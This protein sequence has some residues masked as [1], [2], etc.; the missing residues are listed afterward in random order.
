MSETR[1]WLSRVFSGTVEERAVGGPELGVIPPARDN[2]TYLS[3]EQALSI[4]AVY[5]AVSVI[6]S[7][8]SQMPLGVYRG[9]IEIDTPTLIKQPNVDEP[10]RAFVKKTVYSL[11]TTG[12]AYWRLTGNYPNFQN[13]EVLDPASVTVVMENG[14]PRYGV[15]GREIPANRIK[16]LRLEHVPGQA[17]ALGPIQRGTNE[18]L[19]A[20]QLKWFQDN[21]FSRGVPTGILTTDQTLSPAQAQ[22]YG[23]A[24]N[25][26]LVDQ[27]YGA[28]G[29]LGNGMRYEHLSLNPAQAQFLEIS[30][31]KTVAVARLFGVPATLLASG[32]E[33]ISNIYMN[34][35]ELWLT[36]LQ[37]T[38]TDY[39]NE[40]EDALS[41]LLPRG[42]EVNF[43]EDRLLRMNSQ[44]E[45][46]VRKLQVETVTRTPNELRAIDGLPPLPDG[47]VVP[48]TT[49]S[50]KDTTEDDES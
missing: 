9:G 42:Q 43:K 33:G 15:G 23:E 40:I 6:S 50:D 10:A 19:G 47:Y 1:N 28:T 38:L 36:F 16:H 2:Y 41:S 30:Q 4:S 13:V 26:F 32:N 48:G 17:K 24:W 21:W 7:S 25:K 27:G 39:M 14:K 5:R 45:A 20:L 34:N 18:L 49:N 35:Q 31:S 11:A 3:V 46:T 22:Q 29:V 37:T 12:N 44:L 8:I